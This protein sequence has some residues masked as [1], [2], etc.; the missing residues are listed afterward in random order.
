MS[1]AVDLGIPQLSGVEVVD[2]AGSPV[3]RAHHG[4]LGMAVAVKV[5]TP[6]TEPLVPRR[7][8]IRRKSLAR[9]AEAA[10]VVSVLESGTT[11]TGRAYV[12]MPYFSLGSLL[13]RFDGEP[14]PWHEAVSL[15]A[16]VATVVADGHD[17]GV[18]LGDLKP[19]SVLLSESGRAMVSLYGMA[20]R[21]FDDG[22]PSFSAPERQPGAALTPAA[23]VYSL[24][25]VLVSLLAGRTHRPPESPRAL[26]EALDGA[27]PGSVAAVIR[28]G[29]DPDPTDRFQ[30]ATELRV[31]LETLA[32]NLQDASG[33]SDAAPAATASPPPTEGATA[34]RPRAATSAETNELDAALESPALGAEHFDAD[35]LDDTVDIETLLGAAAAASF[36]ADLRAPEPVDAEPDPTDP[37]LSLAPADAS[38]PGEP[39]DEAAE[40]A[41]E[42]EISA[43]VQPV[44]EAEIAA[45]EQPEPAAESKPD[46]EP[47]DEHPVVPDADAAAAD[48]DADADADAGM[49]ADDFSAALAGLIEPDDLPAGLSAALD[50]EAFDLDST[51]TLPVGRVLDVLPPA[52][53]PPPEESVPSPPA[54]VAPATKPVL[55]AAPSVWGEEPPPDVWLHQPQQPAPATQAGQWAPPTLAARSPNDPLAPAPRSIHGGD[56]LFPRATGTTTGEHPALRLDRTLTPPR[57]HMRRTVDGI[58]MFW[59]DRFRSVGGLIAVL[60]FIAIALIVG[61]L[62]LRDLRST[63]ATT[64]SSLQI[65]TTIAPAAPTVLLPTSILPA[66][67]EPASTHATIEL[68]SGQSERVTTTIPP[69]T[70]TETTV[71][72]TTTDAPVATT[73]APSE[74]ID[75]GLDTDEIAPEGPSRPLIADVSV[76]G[77]TATAAEVRFASDRCVLATFA[78][79]PEGGPTQSID[80]D[81]R[82][83]DAHTLLLGTVTPALSP[84]TPYIVVITAFD[85]AQ[86]Q[87]RSIR[88]VTGE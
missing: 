16:E 38:P 56:D 3:Y 62:F 65:T 59:I 55:E 88:F 69:T 85:G 66:L 27:I 20:T 63:P 34:L 31:A 42:A 44:A 58:Q 54:E 13:D 25:A 19:S 70:T 5:M 81:A 50:N 43:E 2:P 37:A 51:F 84:G 67:N 76:S 30:H 72:P 77:V 78:F 17:L 74:T 41:A 35:P 82:C 87:R 64:T 32:A 46:P 68:R 36:Q 28:K 1:A 40:A 80:G 39:T 33:T 21:R 24:S 75:P 73:E 71:A 83:S 22:S 9:F 61:A 10:G 18:I 7:F 6:H 12:M 53:P 86:S 49:S 26:L 60:G 11:T 8:D 57:G 4:G 79:G 23:D 52:D 47:T 29:L 14:R 15:A 45:E 48:A